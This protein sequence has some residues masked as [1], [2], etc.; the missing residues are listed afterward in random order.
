MVVF[1]LYHSSYEAF[2]GFVMKLKV[3][4]VILNSDFR[5]T[6]HVFSYFRNAQAT[7]VIAPLLPFFFHYLGVDE[8]TFEIS[9]LGTLFGCKLIFLIIIFS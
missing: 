2:E 6:H 5:F 1:V 8:H 9:Q 3:L 4:I 7:F